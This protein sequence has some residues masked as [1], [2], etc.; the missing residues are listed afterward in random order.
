MIITKIHLCNY[1]QYRGLHTINT[2]VNGNSKSIIIFYGENG[3]GKTTIMEAVR[4]AFLGSRILKLEGYAESDYSEFLESAI[5]DKIKGS[6]KAESY[7]QL[8]MLLNNNQNVSVRRD[9]QFHN[10]TY[11]DKLTLLSD[12][13]VMEIIPSDYWEDFLINLIP[14]EVSEYFILDGETINQITKQRKVDDLVKSSAKVLMGFTRLDSLRGDLKLL[15]ESIAERSSKD[16]KV[17]NYKKKTDNELALL[18]SKQN[19]LIIHQDK[20]SGEIEFLENQM[21]QLEKESRHKI[22]IGTKAHTSKKDDLSTVLDQEKEQSTKLHELCDIE[23]PLA[24]LGSIKEDTIAKIEDIIKKEQ[25]YLSDDEKAQLN[26]LMKKALNEKLRSQSKKNR[27]II[28]HAVEESIDEIQSMNGILNYAKDFSKSELTEARELL[29]S[30]DENQLNQYLKE[31]FTELESLDKKKYKIMDMKVNA[32][33]SAFIEQYEALKSQH[34]EKMTEKIANRD[35]LKEITKK[36]DNAKHRRDIYEDKIF[37]SMVNDKKLDLT[38]KANKVLEEYMNQM[39]SEKSKE[40]SE[41]ITRIHLEVAH[42]NDL[43]KKIEVSPDTLKV[44]PMGADGKKISTKKLSTGETEIFHLSVLW[45]MTKISQ[46]KLPILIDAPFEKLD[47]KHVKNLVT[48]LL[49]KIS[50]QT[51]LFVHD[52]ELDDKTV[53]SIKPSILKA[54]HVQRPSMRIGTKI[55]NKQLKNWRGN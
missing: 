18:Y 3:S 15:A 17:Y 54:Y 34:S 50:H 26:N 10:A 35:L 24:L 40:M 13:D 25:L 4:F 39:I 28:L 12:A 47:H 22:G 9:I 41:A 27:E 7:V 8:D 44:I 5:N 52:R 43:I 14:T 6:K 42:K 11:L 33:F 31:I 23:F 29:N 19:D 37:K 2:N 48:K 55:T 38:L 30:I 16:S 51:I 1:R 53:E 32:E 21:M 45:G 49:P 46:N 20:L 36:I